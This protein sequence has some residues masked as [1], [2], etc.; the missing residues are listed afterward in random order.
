M[1]LDGKVNPLRHVHLHKSIWVY[2]QL[3]IYSVRDRD[4]EM[5]EQAEKAKRCRVKVKRM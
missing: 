5:M 4:D 1:E 3:Q 2:K